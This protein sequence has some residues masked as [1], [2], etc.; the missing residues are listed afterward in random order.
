MS[1]SR[2]SLISKGK[3]NVMPGCLLKL[4]GHLQGG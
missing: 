2:S 4:Q 1:M 3:D